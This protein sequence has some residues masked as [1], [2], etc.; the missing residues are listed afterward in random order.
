M[1]HVVY[2][3]I[4]KLLSA[5]YPSKARPKAKVTPLSFYKGLQSLVSFPHKSI[6]ALFEDT[7]T[8]IYSNSTGLLGLLAGNNIR[9][10]GGF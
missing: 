3:C 2:H 1:C 9:A 10:Q 8:L 6:R 4:A 5:K 7:I